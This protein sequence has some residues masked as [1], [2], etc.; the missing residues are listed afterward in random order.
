MTVLKNENARMD[1][2][3]LQSWLDAIVC[4]ATNGWPCVRFY[5][6]YRQYVNET[7]ESV[8]CEELCGRSLTVEA[9][10]IRAAY[11]RGALSVDCIALLKLAGFNLDGQ[12]RVSLAGQ[13]AIRQVNLKRWLKCFR[14]VRAAAKR[15]GNFRF[16][17]N[18]H[19]WVWLAEQRRRYRDGEMTEEQTRLL[20]QA[21]FPLTSCALGRPRT[22]S[23]SA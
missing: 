19:N 13:S 11:R 5:R 6:R 15:R 22:K 21:G 9:S 3:K 16:P 10:R 4:T 2:A 1:D 18:S 8:L 12:R 17:K 23:V 7:G 20:V 14:R